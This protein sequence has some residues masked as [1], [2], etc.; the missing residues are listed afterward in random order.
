MEVLVRT[1][2][3]NIE[4]MEEDLKALNSLAGDLQSSN[5]KLTERL[6][7][8]NDE[9]CE[10]LKIQKNYREVTKIDSAT[11]YEAEKN[12]IPLSEA[13]KMSGNNNVSLPT[14]PKRCLLSLS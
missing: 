12:G 11:Q 3:L 14:T 2:D 9:I 13:K 5:S 1:K 10:L 6:G 7:V 4:K 8:K